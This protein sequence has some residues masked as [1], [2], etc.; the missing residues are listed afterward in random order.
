MTFARIFARGC[1]GTRAPLVSVEVFISRGIPSL[2][3]VGLPQT[4]VRESK[5]RVRSALLHAGFEFPKYRVV[6]N[7]GPADLPKEGGRYDLAIA[8]GL[9][10]ASQQIPTQDLERYEF[11]GELSLS[12]DIRSTNSVLPASLACQNANR[13]LILPYDNL[14]EARLCTSAS[15]HGAKTLQ[16]VCQYLAGTGLLY[17]APYLPPLAQKYDKDMNEVQGQPFPRRALEIA[18]AGRHHLLMIGSPGSGKTMLAERL[19]SIQPS[20][21]LEESFEIA[22]LYS[23]KGLWDHTL[24]GQRPFRSPHHS[25]SS[26]ALVGGGSKPMP[27]EISLAQHGVL[28]LDEL[29]E[30]D[31]RA[32]EVL[33][34]PLESRSITLARAAYQI[35]YPAAFQLVAAMNPCPCG[36]KDDPHRACEC[37]PDIIAR[38]RAKLSGPLL[39]RIDLQV[40]VPPIEYKVLLKHTTTSES[41]ADIQVRVERAAQIQLLRQGCYNAQLSPK[42]FPTHA[43]MSEEATQFLLKAAN[44]LYLSAR[45]VHRVIRVGRTI[46]DLN[47]SLNMTQQHLSE[48]LAFRLD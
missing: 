4:A 41:S 33:R 40:R 2:S 21:T 11:I 29:P 34:E 44:R 25:S 14:N 8:I 20:L 13:L 6:V 5:D 30:F 22:T 19:S 32:I 9:L 48:A 26:V 15:N 28:F 46:A 1:I 27:G 38:Y 10:A 23:C 35:T 37:N 17:Q 45:G 7:L 31:R 47:Q 42:H 12:G 3:M 36:Y 43:A 16:E 39:D 24:W 18:A